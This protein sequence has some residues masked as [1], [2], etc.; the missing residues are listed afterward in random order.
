MAYFVL[1]MVHGPNWD[2]SRP[3]REQQGWDD[4]AAFMDR[5]TDDGFV[6]L[7]GPLGDGEQALL[8]AEA[9]DEAQARSRVAGDPWAEM[10]LLHIG[11]VQPWTIWLDGR[12]RSSAS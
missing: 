6:I 1:T 12:A 8:I 11:L 9:A 4:H 7:G 5:L 10:D 3:I 2:R